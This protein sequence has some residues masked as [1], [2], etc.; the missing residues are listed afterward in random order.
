MDLIKKFVYGYLM[1]KLIA[2]DLTFLIA[3]AR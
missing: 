2:I 1:R 3:R